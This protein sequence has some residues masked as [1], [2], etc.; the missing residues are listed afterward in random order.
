MLKYYSGGKSWNISTK[1]FLV[2][3]IRFLLEFKKIESSSI[4]K[5]FEFVARMFSKAGND[6][7]TGISYATKPN[8]KKRKSFRNR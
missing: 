4:A 6:I 3:L 1:I 7:N 5:D 2:K 8:D